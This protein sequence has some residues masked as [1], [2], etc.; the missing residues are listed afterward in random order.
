M[1]ENPADDW[2]ILFRLPGGNIRREQRLYP[3]REAAERTAEE[4]PVFAACAVRLSWLQSTPKS[5]W[6]R[7]FDEQ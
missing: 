2:T 5:E 6:D 3:D 7:F 4:S 1:D